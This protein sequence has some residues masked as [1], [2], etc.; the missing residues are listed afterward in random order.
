LT[1]PLHHAL[2]PNR[3]LYV[4]LIIF[5]LLRPFRVLGFDLGFATVIGRY[6]SLLRALMLW[7]GAEVHVTKELD[8]EGSDAWMLASMELGNDPDA[9][10]P[11]TRS[12]VLCHNLLAKAL[13][14]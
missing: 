2:H 3:W 7:P 1:H 14:S 8:I 12:E 13:L 6:K 10:E 5:H 4:V 11:D 9:M